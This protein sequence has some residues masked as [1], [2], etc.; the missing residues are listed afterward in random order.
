[1]HDQRERWRLLVHTRV[2]DRVKPND[3]RR[4]SYIHFRRLSGLFLLPRQ[5]NN[6]NY[7]AVGDCDD[8]DEDD[9]A[10]L[11]RY[12]RAEESEDYRLLITISRK[13]VGYAPHSQ[14]LHPIMY[15]VF[16]TQELVSSLSCLKLAN[17]SQI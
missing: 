8:E 3:R 14:N 5:I 1:M 9:V 13:L 16:T 10:S 4:F 15:V 12:S 7:S 6:V 17:H 2:L 11:R